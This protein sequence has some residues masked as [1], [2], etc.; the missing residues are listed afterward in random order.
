M[1][2]AGIYKVCTL[3]FI[4]TLKIRDM[5]EIVCIKLSAL[6]Y[7]IRLYIVIEYGDLKSITLLLEY[8]LN[9]LK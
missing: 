5:L 8:G 6:H 1:D 9:L 3:L 2:A 7:E 4:E